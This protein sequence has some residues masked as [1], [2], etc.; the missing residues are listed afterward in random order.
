M[1]IEEL[2]AHKVGD[3]TQSFIDATP[4]WTGNQAGGRITV[5]TTGTLTQVKMKLSQNSAVQSGTMTV[6]VQNNSYV[7]I[8]TGTF[9]LTTIPKGDPAAWY[10][11]TLTGSPTIESGSLLN[12]RAQRDQ[13]GGINPAWRKH[14]VDAFMW[15][16]WGEATPPPGKPT[17]PSPT[18]EATNITLDETPLSWDASDPAADTY[19]IY[20]REQGDDWTKVG[21]AQVAIEWAIAS[22]T[23]GYNTTYEWRIDATNAYGTTTGD[24]WYFSAIAFDPPLPTGVTLD[25][26]GNPTGTPTGVNNM[27][28]IR[29]LVLAANNKIW[30][31]D[32]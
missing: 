25:A 21:D 10:T 8:A 12:I 9:G 17:N 16:V 19:E 1:A 7:T 15:A 23:L 24:T 28:T 2:G 3:D 6:E 31:E 30:Y 20:F 32:I 22:G 29:K 27:M 11:I 4:N 14:D 13:S 5:A 26:N 18:N